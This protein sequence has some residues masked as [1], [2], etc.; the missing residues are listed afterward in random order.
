MDGVANVEKRCASS[1]YSTSVAAYAG[2]ATAGFPRGGKAKLR[3][4]VQCWTISK[5][6]Q[7]LAIT[8][9]PS[10][11]NVAAH[12]ARSGHAR[13][14]ARCGIVRDILALAWFASGHRTVLN[15]RILRI[16]PACPRDRHLVP[17]A[18]MRHRLPRTLR[19]S[20]LRAQT[21]YSTHRALTRYSVLRTLMP[22]SQTSA[23]CRKTKLRDLAPFRG[24]ES[25][26]LA[27]RQRRE[28]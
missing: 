6:G 7:S 4:R 24:S 12:D 28:K 2:T 3:K 27:H 19:N 11:V 14:S 1:S 23:G 22:S 18:L 16:T 13:E 9:G 5:E 26:R 20:L 8:R 21:C 17:R 25:Q 10:A 15:V